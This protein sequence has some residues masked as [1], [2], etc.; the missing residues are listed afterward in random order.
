M[1]ARFFAFLILIF[2]I[3][4]PVGAYYYFTQKQIASITIST[5]TG[6]VFVTHLSGTF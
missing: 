3:G 4:V 1:R 5:G 6:V 2:L